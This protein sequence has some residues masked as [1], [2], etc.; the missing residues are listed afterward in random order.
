MVYVIGAKSESKRKRAWKYGRAVQY[1]SEIGIPL[2]DLEREVKKRGGLEAVAKE[3]AQQQPRRR[4]NTESASATTRSA[5]KLDLPKRAAGIQTGEAASNRSGNAAR[6]LPN[7]QKT[8]LLIEIQMSDL[9]E[10]RE[11][12][13]G[14]RIKLITTRLRE[15]RH[16]L[17][18][19][20]LRKLN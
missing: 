12:K 16:L 8:S 6:D 5:P 15:G 9:D 11:L 18:V 20:R 10:L 13:P 1:L 7:D 14:E 19:N 17:T 3:A 4:K 2:G